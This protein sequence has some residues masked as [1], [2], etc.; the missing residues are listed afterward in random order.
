MSQIVATILGQRMSRIKGLDVANEILSAKPSP[1]VDV[2]DAN[3]LMKM[4][5]LRL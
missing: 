1:A 4:T 5:Y 3:I 2:D